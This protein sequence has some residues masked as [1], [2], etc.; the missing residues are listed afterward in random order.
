MKQIV[1]ITGGANGLGREL[2]AFLSGKYQVIIFDIDQKILKTVA[3]KFDS[4]FQ[5]CDV[6]NFKSLSSAIKNVIKKYSQIDYFINSAGVFIDGPIEKND[7]HRIRQVFEVNCLGPI[8]AA[9]ILIPIF[10]K[11]KKGTIINI[12]STAGLH[13]KAGNSVYHSSK[14]ALTGFSE[15]LQLELSGSKIKV[16][17]IH[18]GVMK[19]N[20]THGTQADI[21]SSI[22]PAEVVKVIDFILSFK[23]NILIPRLTIKHL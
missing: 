14:W 1:C 2:V 21:S 19:T 6:S 8:F 16:I 11:Q 17:D 15:S 20:F 12:N 23:S 4:D 9:N 7:P 13:P 22:D 3:Q 5:V 18:P 10:K